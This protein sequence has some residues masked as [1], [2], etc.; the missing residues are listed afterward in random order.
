MCFAYTQRSPEQLRFA[1]PLDPLASQAVDVLPTLKVLQQLTEDKVEPGVDGA[2]DVLLEPKRVKGLALIDFPASALLAILQAGVPVVSVQLPHSLSERG[3]SRTLE[4][5]KEY[6][7]K[8]G[9]NSFL[10]IFWR[11]AVCCVAVDFG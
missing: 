6:G 4:L 5:A 11:K 7:I 3:H 10:P 8:V 1:E 2:E 9:G